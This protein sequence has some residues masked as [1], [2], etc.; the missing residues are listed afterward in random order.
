MVTV[1]AQL[2]ALSP[3]IPQVAGTLSLQFPFLGPSYPPHRLPIPP[4]CGVPR[5][6]QDRWWVSIS[7]RLPLATGG[8]RPTMPW[9]RNCRSDPNPHL[10]LWVG[11]LGF[12]TPFPVICPALG[13]VV[14][15]HPDCPQPPMPDCQIGWVPRH[16]HACQ[17]RHTLG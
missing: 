8:C 7:E 14:C 6:F 9:I 2:L 15:T 11:V 17:F 16:G 1:R 12:P 5:P 4:A 3:G 13:L 10:A